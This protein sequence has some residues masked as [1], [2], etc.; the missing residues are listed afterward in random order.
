MGRK[1]IYATNSERQRHF[2]QL[3]KEKELQ[4]QIEVAQKLNINQVNQKTESFE[5]LVAKFFIGKTLQQVKEAY[6]DYKKMY[7]VIGK[8]V[9]FEEIHHYLDDETPLCYSITIGEIDQFLSVFENHIECQCG[10]FYS[11]FESSCPECNLRIHD[12]SKW[13]QYRKEYSE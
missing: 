7:K 11:H 3:K 12:Y 8:D 10:Y 6:T 5:S 1:R 9:L 4:Q 2:Q 13:K